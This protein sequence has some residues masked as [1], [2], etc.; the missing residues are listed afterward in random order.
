VILDTLPGRA[1]RVTTEVD[2]KYGRVFYVVDKVGTF[3]IE[4]D[5]YGSTDARADTLYIHYGRYDTEWRSFDDE[6]LPEAPVLYGI[7]LT[8]F[9]GF[10]QEKFT[11]AQPGGWY[12]WP[13]RRVRAESGQP[14]WSLRDSS[15][16]PD[17]T[18][19]RV[20]EICGVIT[21]DYLAR[22]D[23]HAIERARAAH[24]APGRLRHH[25]KRIAELRAQIGKAQAELDRE[26]LIA[27]QVAAMTAPVAAAS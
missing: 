18:R 9:C 8:S 6:P 17:G 27:D 22:S 14:S 25:T 16:V 1:L 20:Y 4:R 13:V 21:L 24:L 7:T 5:Q 11:N 3:T 10:G 26:L 12:Q 23:Y 2:W 19:K 15:T